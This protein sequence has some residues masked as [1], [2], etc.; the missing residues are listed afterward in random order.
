MSSFNKQACHGQFANRPRQ[1]IGH[2]SKKQIFTHLSRAMKVIQ[3]SNQIQI[4]GEVFQ[5]HITNNLTCIHKFTCLQTNKMFF[6][7]IF[8]CVLIF[9]FLAQVMIEYLEGEGMKG[10]FNVKCWLDRTTVL[11]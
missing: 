6:A 2:S 9:V 10:R 4:S 3:P 1:A 5:F 7:D 11:W 8:L